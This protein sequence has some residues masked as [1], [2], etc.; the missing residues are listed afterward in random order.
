MEIRVAVAKLPKYGVGESG[1]TVEVVERPRGGL[2]AIIADGQGSGPAAKRLSRLVVARALALLADG[3]RDG[4][5]ARAVHDFLFAAREGKVS[6]DL[7]LVSADLWSRTLVIS[8]NS[9]CPVLVVSGGAFRRLD[10][11]AEPIGF[12]ESLR[13]AV[14]QVPMEPGTVV[15]AMT[16]GVL[17]AGRRGERGVPA[18]L[19]A[20]ALEA[21]ARSPAAACDRILDWAVAQDAGRPGDDMTVVVLGLAPEVAG[22][23]VRRMLVSFPV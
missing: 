15:V 16:D 13:P 14:A 23:K 5:V 20:L 18:E 10:E 22:E 11:P 6:T 17:A 21:D 9:A 12:R 8:R 4:A 19:E 2:T 3:A 7:T 1:D